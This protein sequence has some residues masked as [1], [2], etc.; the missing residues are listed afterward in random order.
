MQRT[1][2]LLA[3]VIACGVVFYASVAAQT[4]HAFNDWDWIAITRSPSL[5]LSALTRYES[6]RVVSQAILGA[7]FS[8]FGPRAWVPAILLTALNLA[9]LP[10]LARV[11]QRLGLTPR[12]AWIAAACAVLC[13][14]SQEATMF[15]ASGEAALGRTAVL[16]VLDQALAERPRADLRAAA[17]LVVAFLTHEMAVL[18]VP[19][20][21][22]VTAAR[23][24]RLPRDRKVL[25]ATALAL[26]AARVALFARTPPSTHRL[27]TAS[28]PANLTYFRRAWVQFY[29]GDHLVV[30][31]LALAL[32]L[33]VRAERRD[34][35]AFGL[36]LAVSAA[37]ACLA[38]APYFGA[39]AYHN[40]Y[41]FTLAAACAAAPIGWAFDRAL[42]ALEPSRARR[43]LVLAAAAGLA[44]VWP[45]RSLRLPSDTRAL[46]RATRDAA[47][48][49]IARD[50]GEGERCLWLVSPT[51]SARLRSGAPAAAVLD[52][53]HDRTTNMLALLHPG[54][55]FVLVELDPASLAHAPIA[56]RD[57]VV[58][59]DDRGLPHAEAAA[60]RAEGSARCAR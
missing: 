2:R 36:V 1:N 33:G 3:I 35:R 26:T 55:R 56:A 5:W 14:A 49:A 16:L 19:L 52:A 40:A 30:L 25:L 15:L 4:E 53:R 54:Q 13:R 7:S 31:V 32:L 18:A 45:V 38:Y 6:V 44:V 28:I 20:F 34:G 50:G 43:A 41:F 51:G 60:G 22:L 27:T 12:A 59:L 39:S 58:R 48:D 24:R 29:L 57:A 21:L 46:T 37:A 42:E 11:L 9:S 10:L 17:C 47:R 8:L 23:D